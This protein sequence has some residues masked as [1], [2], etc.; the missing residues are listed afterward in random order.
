VKRHSRTV[1]RPKLKRPEFAP[2][3]PLGREVQ[4]V[5]ELIRPKLTEEADYARFDGY[6]GAASEAYLHLARERRQGDN[7]KVMRRADGD[8]SHW[9]L[10]DESGRVIDL[11]LAP[12][13][14]R[15]YK[16]GC[17]RDAAFRCR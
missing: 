16:R 13:D 10:L 12:S 1:R 9:W 6:C 5:L 2:L 15:Y 11:T 8:S 17:R 4:R 3:D 14:R 7:L